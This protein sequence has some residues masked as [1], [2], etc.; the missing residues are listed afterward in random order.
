LRRAEQG[1][2]QPNEHRAIGPLDIIFALIE[3]RFILF[4]L[5]ARFVFDRLRFFF[6]F[7]RFIGV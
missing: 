6:G 5:R 3:R 2:Y 1:E 4:V 7:V